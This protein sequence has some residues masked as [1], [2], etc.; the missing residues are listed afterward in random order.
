[1]PLLLREPSHRG[2]VENDDGAIPVGVAQETRTFNHQVVPAQVSSQVSRVTGVGLKPNEHR[3]FRGNEHL[4]S[5][6]A[7]DHPR[8]RALVLLLEPLHP[9]HGSTG[10]S[11]RS[12]RMKC[13]GNWD[14][15]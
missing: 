14:T 6:V 1:M 15:V 10:M 5:G 11:I 2:V 9:V 8:W 13:G 7:P 12:L 3:P 4:A